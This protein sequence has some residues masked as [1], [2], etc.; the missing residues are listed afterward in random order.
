MHRV[1]AEKL[2]EEG[3]GSLVI[4]DGH[5]QAEFLYW[6]ASHECSL[7]ASKRKVSCFLK[8]QSIN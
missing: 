3:F 4:G 5:H 8:S 1:R 7:P 2:L 6:I